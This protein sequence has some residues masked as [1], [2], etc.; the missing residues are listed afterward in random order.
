MS[1]FTNSLDLELSLDTTKHINYFKMCLNLLPHH[2]VGLDCSRLTAIYFSVTGLDILGALDEIDKSSIIDYIYALQINPNEKESPGT[3]SY[4]GFIGGTY[5]GQSFTSKS[6]VT[7]TSHIQDT[8]N[9]RDVL[10]DDIH[11]TET[12]AEV[13]SEPCSNLSQYMEGHLAMNYTAIASL[14][15]L[16]DDLSGVNKVTLLNSIRQLQL[17]DGSFRATS[18]GSECDMRFLYCAC[19]V[20][21]LLNDWSPINKESAVNYIL[22]CITYEGGLS[23]TPGSE[24]HGGSTYCGFASLVLMNRQDAMSASQKEDLL[25]WC[26][27]RQIGGF[28]GRTNKDPDSCYS[29]WV[30]A[31]ISLLDGL[32]DS[33]LESTGLFLLGHCQYFNFKCNGGF[34]KMPGAAPDILHSFFSL[35]WLAMSG[36]CADTRDIHPAVGMCRDKLPKHFNIY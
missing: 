3:P 13:V 18:E 14:L 29:Y 30:G 11:R 27:H 16:G 20:C 12:K 34:S 4:G 17:D 33:D 35:C 1:S 22:H 32:S 9:M 26:M 19:A 28:Q 36:R 15:A 7:A 6:S 24:A 31:T 25:R 10:T 23:L 5:L 21:A 8:E 2:Y